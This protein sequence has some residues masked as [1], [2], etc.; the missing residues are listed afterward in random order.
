MG[1]MRHSAR[2]PA[3]ARPRPRERWKRRGSSRSDFDSDHRGA[4]RSPRD[5]GGTTRSADM[6]EAT[7][8]EAAEVQ[9][10]STGSSSTV[11]YPPTWRCPR[12]R[13][14]WGPTGRGAGWSGMARSPP[15]SARSRW[16]AARHPRRPRGGTRP[17]A[18][19]HRGRGP[20]APAPLRSVMTT[21]DGRGRGTAGAA[22][23]R[24]PRGAQRAGGAG[25]VRGQ[26]PL[27]RTRGVSEILAE[28]PE[29]ARLREEIRDT[30]GRADR[31]SASTSAS[32]WSGRSRPSVRPTPRR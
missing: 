19:R 11:S 6:A 31:R 15:W 27:R 1:D 22:P 5:A 16:T 4:R 23:R 25:R 7:T 13:A 21:P 3:R 8:H 9:Q 29:I 28:H 10:R 14:G 24:L 18:G 32:S 20:G 2:S 30:A 17:T 26:G 12:T